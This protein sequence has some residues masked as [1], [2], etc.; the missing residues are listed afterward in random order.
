MNHHLLKSL[1]AMV[2]AFVLLYYGIAWTV[3]RCS[4]D[5][6]HADHEVALQDLDATHQGF[7]HA[8]LNPVGLDLECVGP[9]FHTEAM[10]AASSPPQPDRFSLDIT[11]HVND[12]LTLRTV[13]GDAAADTWLR[14]VFERPPS[15]AFLVGVPS[16]LFLSIFRI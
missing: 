10:A 15:L 16:Y 14:T 12:F 4:H 3:L 9:N 8:S 7:Y 11:P 5:A 6:K 1:V 2:V 13:T